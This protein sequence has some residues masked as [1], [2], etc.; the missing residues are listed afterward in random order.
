MKRL[1]LLLLP[2][3]TPALS[4]AQGPLR[5]LTCRGKPGID[6]KVTTRPS[7]IN[8]KLVR[9]TLRYE[10]STQSLGH[11]FEGLA[12]GSC[13]W[14][15]SRL[16][17]VPVEPG[18]VEFDVVPEMQNWFGTT[19]RT[20]DT[21]YTA[22][23]FLPDTISIPRFLN[24]TEHLWRFFVY[25]QS[26]LAPSFGGIRTLTG[27]TFVT[28]TG[29][30]GNTAP[31]VAELRCRG[32]AGISFGG[33]TRVADNRVR[34]YMIYRIAD[35]EAGSDAGGL[36]PGTCAWVKRGTL[37]RET[38]RIEFETAGN[39]QLAQIR[40]GGTVDKSPTAAARYADANTIPIYMQDA[41]RYWNFHV[42]VA[43][44]GEA[45][46]HAA[47][48]P[49]LTFT[50]RTID[51]TTLQTQPQ[52][53]TSR[54]REGATTTANTATLVNPPLVF[55]ELIRKPNEYWIRF[56]ARA[57]SSPSVEYST[58]AP[59][60]ISGRLGFRN[61][62]P[63]SVKTVTSRQYSADYSTAPLTTLPAGKKYYFVINVPKGSGGL[64]AGEY[65]GEFTTLTQNVIV[66]FNKID[67]L[68]DSDKDSNGE[69]EFAFNLT[70][71]PGREASCE[72]YGRDNCVAHI[73]PFSWSSGSSHTINVKLNQNR[74]PFKIRV[75]VNGGDDDDIE[76]TGSASS[77]STQGYYDA[78]GHSDVNGDW[79][80]ASAEFDLTKNVPGKKTWFKLRSVDGSVL[81]FEVYGEIE[82]VWF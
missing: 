22:G 35:R 1:S 26:N 50:S 59:T 3:L 62:L 12:P 41:G 61:P 5:E 54:T 72:R 58:E 57:N 49:P 7:P 14:N 74:M 56:S 8:T 68:N 10:R 18:I 65:S 23:A 63:M 43:K 39:A 76:H 77:T 51:N 29:P 53:V 69:L 82:V 71:A 34:M 79:N 55:R 13:T 78:T 37:P 73:G 6:L 60:R 20:I 64:S 28:L 44:P 38:A 48:K 45:T 15:P 66:T 17:N 24:R 27:P 21:T 16:A 81:M 31:T 33:G 40:S 42:T 30:F 2:L 32:G 70:A 36:G 46:S 19:T 80:T 75:W 47:W 67:V 9:M 52:T 4:E 11:N 25:D